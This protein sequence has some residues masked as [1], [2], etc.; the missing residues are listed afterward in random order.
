MLTYEMR[1]KLMRV[2]EANPEL[3]QRA[4]AKELGVSLGKVNFCLQAL[5]QKGLVKVK[6]FSNSENKAA[7]MYLLTPRGIE[8]K[9][10]LAIQYLRA[11]RV[12]YEALRSEIVRLQREVDPN[13]PF[14][15]VED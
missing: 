3:S 15:Q 2:L 1:Y 6:N 9:A 5:I 7:Y 10:T 4:L 13:T 11:K 12:E 14:N 8:H